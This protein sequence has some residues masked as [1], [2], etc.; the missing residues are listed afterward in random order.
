MSM[1]IRAYLGD[2]MNIELLEKTS[3]KII[4][5]ETRRRILVD[6]DGVIVSYDFTDLVWE[7]FH[8]RINPHHIF[9]Y[10]L[11]DVLGVTSKAID[12]MF[13]DQ[14]WGKPEFIKGAIETLSEWKSKYEIVIYSN[15]VKYMGYDGLTRWLID[16]GVP[17]S[18]ITGGQGFYAFHIDDRPKKLCDTN[19]SV[20]LLFTQPWNL[21][22]LN[23]E[24]R[25]TRVNSWQEIRDIVK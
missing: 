10:N 5:L 1:R 11:A 8:I 20:K 2:E 6:V 25:L 21:R 23:I 16:S 14:V 12:E 9:A 22:C 19:S 15:R 4:S 24:N 18:G 3:P 7:K 13:F 17:F